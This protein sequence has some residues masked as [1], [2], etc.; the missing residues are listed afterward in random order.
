[1]ATG[2]LEVLNLKPPAGGVPAPAGG[3]QAAPPVG[4][5][6]P[7]AGAPPAPPVDDERNRN[8]AKRLI[9]ALSKGFNANIARGQAAVDAQ[10][11]EALKKSLGTELDAFAT[12][13]AA[14][15]KAEPLEGARMMKKLDSDAHQFALRAEALRKSAADGVQYLRE[16][17]D[18]PYAD[19]KATFDAQPAD[20]QAVYRARF[21]QIKTWLDACRPLLDKG[22]IDKLIESVGRVYIQGQD[23]KRAIVEHAYRQA[24]VRRLA[25][26]GRRDDPAHA[27][28][29]DARRRRPGRPGRARHRRSRRPTRSVR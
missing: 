18:L 26:G 16:R 20:V 14:V 25:Q 8:N 3:P 6:A 7:P 9:E 27:R 10:P 29:Q 12:T 28:Q 24:R 11:V 19:L 22:E 23:L 2:L 21:D 13:R 5:G 17:G 1:M 4:A 15:D